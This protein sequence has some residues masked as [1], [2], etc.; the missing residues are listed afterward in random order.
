MPAKIISALRA[1]C[2]AYMVIN[3]HGLK[4][5]AMQVA[6]KTGFSQIIIIITT[7]RSVLKNERDTVNRRVH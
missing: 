7:F 3:C 4:A 5:V 2:T 1:L 6:D